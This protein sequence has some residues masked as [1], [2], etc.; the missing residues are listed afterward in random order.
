MGVDPQ[1][2]DVM[3]RAPRASGDRILDGRV[4]TG[5]LTIGLDMGLATLLTIDVFLPGG[6]VEGG[7]SLEVARTAGFTT[8]VFAQLFNAFNSRSET[9]A[10]S[11]GTFDNAWLWGSAGL[12]TPRTG[13][14]ASPRP[15]PCSGSTS[16]AS[17]RT[18]PATARAPPG[19][20]IGPTQT[21]RDPMS[22]TPQPAPP[23]A[24]RGDC[25]AADAADP[26]R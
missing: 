1:V 23:Q 22:A 8:L 12:D 18:G 13:P 16:C 24:T 21:R 20:L 9:P 6:L 19:R 7:D 25:L 3:A 4:R 5:I 10:R 11:A 14:S 17:S 26:L 15:R 2:D